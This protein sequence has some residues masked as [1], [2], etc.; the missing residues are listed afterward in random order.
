MHNL[1]AWL[2]HSGI[3]QYLKMHRK[4][5]SKWISISDVN[6]KI[7]KKKNILYTLKVPF[8]VAVVFFFFFYGGGE[9]NSKEIIDVLPCFLFMVHFQIFR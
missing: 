5:I 4:Y 1:R 6:K 2:S 9:D 8:F 3:I 7:A